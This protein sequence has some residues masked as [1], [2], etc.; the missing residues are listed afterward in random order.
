[1][2][3]IALPPGSL[4]PMPTDAGRRRRARAATHWRGRAVRMRKVAAVRGRRWRATARYGRKGRNANESNG[5][6]ES[7][8]A[9]TTAG[10]TQCSEPL[11]RSQMCP[12]NKPRGPERGVCRLQ[13]YPRQRGKR[14]AVARW[15]RRNRTR[16]WQRRPRGRVRL[17]PGAYRALRTMPRHW[18]H[19]L[20]PRQRRL[21]LPLRGR[22][23]GGD[24]Y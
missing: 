7:C 17:R 15:V 23:Y 5:L 8:E 22:E 10:T 11:R 3:L 21:P 19:F 6:S 13:E 2:P 12:I 14:L 4:K 24:R 16:R 1:M 18:L 20:G 9:G